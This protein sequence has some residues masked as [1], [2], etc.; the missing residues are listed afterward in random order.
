MDC[1]REVDG[2]VNV[3]VGSRGRGPGLGCRD[4]PPRKGRGRGGCCGLC[5]PV[6]K[7]GAQVG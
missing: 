7:D 1:A 2:L 4:P 6:L 5:E 3:E